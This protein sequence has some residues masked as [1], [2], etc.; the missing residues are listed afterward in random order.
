MGKTRNPKLLLE[1]F[2]GHSSQSPA[3]L[4][5]NAGLSFHADVGRNGRG[6]W[7]PFQMVPEAYHDE[8]KGPNSARWQIVGQAFPPSID[9]VSLRRAK[10]VVFRHHS[11]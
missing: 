2:K 8:I 11:A 4:N 9:A 10:P 7:P 1:L 6:G 3:K 5:S